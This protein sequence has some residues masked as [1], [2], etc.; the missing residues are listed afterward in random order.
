MY[1]SHFGLHD[2]PFGITPDT[3]FFF[4]FGSHREA[5]NTLMIAA[6]SGEGFI[7]I[8]G[9]VGTGKTLLCRQFLK[10]L[11]AEFVTAYIPNPFLE[12]RTLLLSLADDL[13]IEHDRASEQHEVLKAIN[14]RLL[15]FAKQGKRV[16][17]CI[18]EA[19]ALPIETLE[20]IRL[21]SNLETEKRKLLQIVLFGQP[22]LDRRLARDEIRQLAQRIS[23][24]YRLRPL[25]LDE[26]AFYL[27]HRLRVAGYSELRLFTRSANFLLWLGSG[28]IPRMLNIL[29]N[30]SMMLA[31]GAGARTVNLR[32]V[33]LSLQD[34]ETASLSKYMQKIIRI[35]AICGICALSLFLYIREMK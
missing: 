18:D 29:A 3:S 34:T 27:N 9:E 5:F 17:L 20:A 4:S 33:I 31:Y 22:E 19:Q 26:A 7:K 2:V 28:G 1:Q 21:L 14:L 8:T 12:P 32:H 23:F 13:G 35:G 24:H 6:Q 25:S 16:L 15:E 10:S 30:K 11:G